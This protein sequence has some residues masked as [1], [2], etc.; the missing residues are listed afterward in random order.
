[1]KRIVF[2]VCGIVF[3]GSSS[4][5]YGQKF[6]NEKEISAPP[7]V[8]IPNFSPIVDQIDMAVVNVASMTDPKPEE[9]PKRKRS[10]QQPQGPV[11]PFMNPEEFFERFF[12]QPF[13]DMAPQQR[14]A[15]GSGFIISKDGYILTN[16]HVIE[17][18]D[19]IEVT[20]LAENSHDKKGRKF[21]AKVVGRDPA[22]DVALLKIK[23]D[24]DLPFAPL[25]NSTRI[26]KGEWVLAFGNPF[27]LDHSVSAGIISATGR[28]ITPN[29]NRRFDDF[30]QTDAAINF[31]N[32][33]GPLVNMRG[34]V[35]GINTAITAQGS[36]IG[37]AVPV[38]LVKEVI[39]QLKDSGS[40]TRGYLGVMIQDVTED[41]QEA[42]G[43]KEAKGVLVNDVVPEGPAAKSALQRGDI[44]MK[45]NSEETPDSRTLQK[46]I[47][48]TKPETMVNM[49]VVREKK[50]IKLSVKVGSLQETAAKTENEESEAKADILGLLVAMAP[51][52]TGVI[53]QDLNENSAA[54][55]AGVLPGD[56]IRKING[57]PIKTVEEY[58]KVV[59]K[60]KS[61]QTVLLDLERRTTKLFIAFRLP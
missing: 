11:D 9:Q 61:K 10:P 60:L 42:L 48:R 47:A 18:F 35:I 20:L 6:W 54:A 13:R 5:S 57:A 50:P 30:I 26:K 43:L 22:T 17:G 37:F 14:R 39:S 41:M 2:L 46:I 55:Q 15:L 1:M 58:K 44:I 34:E 36:G 19:K 28:E 23:A 33:G 59:S 32:S 4:E 7:L 52:G 8:N 24:Y 49:E 16:N 21:Q 40:V 27:G 29:E 25:G 38:N 51:D 12:G 45:I 53:I 56:A 31:G 3:L